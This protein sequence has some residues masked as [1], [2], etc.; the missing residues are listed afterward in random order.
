MTIGLF[1]HPRDISYI[2]DYKVINYENPR[3]FQKVPR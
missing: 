3:F 2:N 1:A